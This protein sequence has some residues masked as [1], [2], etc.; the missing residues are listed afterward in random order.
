[1]R[2]SFSR[3]MFVLLFAVPACV[4]AAIAQ[5]AAP[6]QDSPAKIYEDARNEFFSAIDKFIEI[7]PRRPELS[8]DDRLRLLDARNKIPNLF[9][10]VMNIAYQQDEPEFSEWLRKGDAESLKL[11]RAEFLDLAG[12]Y[13]ARFVGSLFRQ[14]NPPEFLMSLPH[15]R[16]KGRLDLVLQTLGYNAKND[17]PDLSVEKRFGNKIEPEFYNQWTVTAPGRRGKTIRWLRTRSTGA[18]MALWSLPN[19]CWS[20]PTVRSCPSACSTVT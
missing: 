9:E 2:S 11:F 14:S 1:M 16:G 7:H 18:G 12:V 10:R 15:N 5:T 3:I 4:P 8:G 19:S 6:Q 17:S 20:R 13:A